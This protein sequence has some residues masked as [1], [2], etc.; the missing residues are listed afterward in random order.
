MAEP[1]RTVMMV[2]RAGSAY[3]YPSMPHPGYHLSHHPGYTPTTGTR[4]V[5]LARCTR[6]GTGSES[7]LWALNRHCVTLAGTHIDFQERLSGLWL[8]F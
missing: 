4:P 2:V 1:A 7:V 3:M 8:L 5:T 6:T